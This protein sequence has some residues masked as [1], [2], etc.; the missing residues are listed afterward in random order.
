MRID[1]IE[2]CCTPYRKVLHFDQVGIDRLIRLG[3][4]VYN[5]N[6]PPLEE[7][8]HKDAFEIVLFP[9]GCQT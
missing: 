8:S 6:C 5:M 4:V 3:E 9:S 1:N 7:H 2:D